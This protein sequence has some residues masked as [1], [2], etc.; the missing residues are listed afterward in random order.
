MNNE[1]TQ[2]QE[3]KP[4]DTARETEVS[5]EDT[6]IGNVEEA[7][8]MLDRADATAKRIEEANAKTEALIRRQEQVAARMLLAGKTNAGQVKSPEE[9]T[10]DSDEE[11]ALAIVNRFKTH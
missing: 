9:M 6:K 10:K 5:N 7:P 3:S 8:N 2:P 11:K 1:E 4:E